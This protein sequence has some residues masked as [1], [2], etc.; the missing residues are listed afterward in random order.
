MV[1]VRGGGVEVEVEVGGDGG[2]RAGGKGLG[3]SATKVG[4]RQ[5]RDIDGVVCHGR[6]DDSK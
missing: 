3:R 4:L 1:M 2:G 5:S 6:V